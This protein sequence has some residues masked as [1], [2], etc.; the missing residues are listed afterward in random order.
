MN[1][2]FNNDPLKDEN[3][4]ESTQNDFQAAEPVTPPEKEAIDASPAKSE[5][6]DAIPVPRADTAHNITPPSPAQQPI[7]NQQQPNYQQN[8][9]RHPQQQYQQQQYYHQQ[10]QQPTS[11]YKPAEFSPNQSPYY[12]PNSQQPVGQ[13]DPKKPKKSSKGI[14]TFTVLLIACV[15]IAVVAM[16]LAVKDADTPKTNNPTSTT[17]SSE[18]ASNVINSNNKPTDTDKNNEVATQLSA[19]AE[20]ASKIAPSVVAITVNPNSY[21][22]TAGSGFIVSENG[23]IV[24]NYHVVSS[25]AD[26][27]AKSDISVL[28]DD[29]NEYEA[30]YIAGDSRND[31]AVIKI[32]ATGLS[33]AEI[34]NS[35]ELMRGDFVM[36]IGNPLGEFQGSVSLGVVSGTGR[37]GIDSSAIPYIQTDAAINPGNSGGPLVNMYGQVVGINTSKVV[38]TGYEGIGFAIPMA[39]AQD[40]I[41]EL[42]ST[43]KAPSYAFIGIKYTTITRTQAEYYNVPVGLRIE[44]IYEKSKIDQNVVQVGDIITEVDGQAIDSTTVL[45]KIMASKKPGDT[46][47]VK[48]YRSNRGLGK[49]YETTITLISSNDIEE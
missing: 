43:G 19:T 12:Y 2:Y 7:Q 23:Y 38:N 15:A 40:I 24:T 5:T 42:I 3:Q 47:N 46:I 32:D 31:I 1:D 16:T 25:V 21:S 34:G 22:P 6:Q 11:G 33:A 48:L 20:V 4:N 29:G 18:Q 37:V 28:L 39:Y 30:K 17:S 26:S 35:D 36:A 27:D 8:I 45:T 9:Y 49:E 14:I 13:P 10:Q 44:A 41:N